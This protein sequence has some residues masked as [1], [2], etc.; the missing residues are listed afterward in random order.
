MIY[1]PLCHRHYIISHFDAAIA[2][3]PSSLSTETAVNRIPRID[4]TN[5]WHGFRIVWTKSLRGKDAKT[6]HPTSKKAGFRIQ[7]VDTAEQ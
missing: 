7:Y 3:P 6:S 4:F 1:N 5:Y 2:S